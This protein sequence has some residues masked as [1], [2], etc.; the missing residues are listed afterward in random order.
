MSV[1]YVE[2]PQ[3]SRYVRL[4]ENTTE[5]ANCSLCGRSLELIHSLSYRQGER[6]SEETPTNPL[7]SSGEVPR[8]PG[9]AAVLS[10]FVP[11]AGQ[12]YNGKIGVG[13]FVVVF[14][15]MVVAGEQYLLVNA[16]LEG[17][18]SDRLYGILVLT[19]LLHFLVIADAVDNAYKG[20]IEFNRAVE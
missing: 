1:R 16:L 13:L 18:E 8:N 20:A 3:C 15:V 4:G 17:L 10:L 9:V 11:G 19:V 2:C 7:F 6:A 14:T 5:E 12:I